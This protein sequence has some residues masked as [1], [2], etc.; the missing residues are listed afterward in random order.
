MAEEKCTESRRFQS[1]EEDLKELKDTV[2]SHGS[3][4]ASLKENQAETKI[5]VKQIF[6]R[7]EDLKVMFKAGTGEANDKWLKVVMELIKAIGIIAGIIAGIKVLG[8]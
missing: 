6:E 8:S 4:I 5:Y 2:K 3:D 7:I 1:I